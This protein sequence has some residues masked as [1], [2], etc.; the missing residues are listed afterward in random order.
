MTLPQ[1]HAFSFEASNVFGDVKR[2]SRRFVWYLATPYSSTD[3][4]VRAL[5]ADLATRA[6]ASLLC[7]GLSA[8][9]PIAAHHPV[10]LKMVREKE[11]THA[12][13]MEICYAMLDR[14]D[15]LI[16]STM[17]GSRQSA[18]VTLEIQR[19]YERRDERNLLYAS[20]IRVNEPWTPRFS[21][22]RLA[23]DGL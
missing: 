15:G 17:D 19:W 4:E 1:L 5:R 21:I 8:Y 18:G 2:S 20:P 13:W 10:S 9:S 16:V 22:S 14:C 11:P 7:G 23:V 12:E 3:A 6:T